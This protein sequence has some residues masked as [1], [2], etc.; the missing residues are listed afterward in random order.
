M[1]LHIR[2]QAYVTTELLEIEISKNTEIEISKNT[3]F[4]RMN[5]R[6]CSLTTMNKQDS[7]ET[8]D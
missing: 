4:N 8:Y 7:S 5:L 6:I 2:L 3:E 1:K